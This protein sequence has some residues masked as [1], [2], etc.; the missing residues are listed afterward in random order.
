MDPLLLAVMVSGAFP[1]NQTP[2]SHS[3]VLCCAVCVPPQGFFSHGGRKAD[4]QIC[5]NGGQGF[6]TMPT[7]G[8]RDVDDCV[9]LPGVCGRSA[10][11]Q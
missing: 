2:F 9:C 1:P 6:T 4:C 5:P 8:A 10:H 11:W 3:A 7:I